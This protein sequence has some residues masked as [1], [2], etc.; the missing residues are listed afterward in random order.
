[1]P[2][3]VNRRLCHDAAH[4]GTLRILEVFAPLLRQ[5][6]VKDAYEEV[7]PI[8][9]EAITQFVHA[10]ARERERLNPGCGR[11]ADDILEWTQ[12][13]DHPPREECQAAK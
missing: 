3:T 2:S 12:S 8:V 5:E 6:E 4:A 7:M 13:K 10:L 1:M 11:A 9:T